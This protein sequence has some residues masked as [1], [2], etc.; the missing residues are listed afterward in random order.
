MHYFPLQDIFRGDGVEL[1][2]DQRHAIRVL[3]GELV[4]ID[5]HA[6]RKITFESVL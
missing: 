5:R 3:A 2:R 1:R 4:L 6:N